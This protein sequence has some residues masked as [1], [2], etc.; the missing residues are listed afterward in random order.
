MPWHVC[1]RY[2]MTLWL[3]GWLIIV[4]DGAESERESPS[5]NWKVKT[6]RSEQIGGVGGLI[7]LNHADFVHRVLQ[8][9]RL[10]MAQRRDF[11]RGLVRGLLNHMADVALRPLPFDLMTRRRFVQTLPPIV[12]CLAAKRAFHGFNHVTRVVMN[13]DAT[14]FSHGFQT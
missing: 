2:G 13:R 6:D 1:A 5:L 12:I 7:R 10:N 8:D 11:A 9:R 14:R 4:S 3:A